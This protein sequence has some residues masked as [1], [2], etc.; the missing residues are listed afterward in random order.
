[1]NFGTPIARQFSQ[2]ASKIRSNPISPQ[3]DR[4]VPIDDQLRSIF[5]M[6]GGRPR[7]TEPGMIHLDLAE[8][9]DKSKIGLEYGE[10]GARVMDSRI[11][12]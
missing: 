9:S 7:D 3:R 2:R 11:G 4:I 8:Q 12:S 1:M 5:A 6:P 10:R